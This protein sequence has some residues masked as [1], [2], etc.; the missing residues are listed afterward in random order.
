MLG[1]RKSEYMES[2]QAEIAPF[3]PILKF[4][5][6]EKTLLSRKAIGLFTPALA[7]TGWLAMGLPSQ[8]ITTSY[9]TQVDT[10]YYNEYRVC[11]ARLL[12]V[13]INAQA[14][15]QAC[16][17]SLRPRD[18]SS[19]VLD[20]KKKTPIAATDA[21]STC[22]QVRYPR[23]LATC[24]VGINHY[25]KEAVNPA[26]L[27]YCSRS[28]LPVRFAEC[29][30]GL[31]SEIK[32]ATIQAMDSCIDASDRV[33]GFLPSFIPASTGTSPIYPP[34]VNPSTPTNPPGV[35]TPENPS[36]SSTT[37]ANP[38]NINPANPSST[39]PVTPENLTPANPNRK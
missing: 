8:A 28:L 23:D 38:G 37:P 12:S 11:A 24:V 5:L 14:I 17:T 9:N 3:H 20:I 13:N 19:C 22:S 30:V 31:H 39:T 1:N 16:S 4:F 2:P 27:N 34:S 35:S 6:I 7:L 15:A 32:V 29:V 36:G 25:S 33:S 18:V 26:I 21:L 10:S